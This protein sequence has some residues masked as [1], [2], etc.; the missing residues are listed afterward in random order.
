MSIVYDANIFITEDTPENED[1]LSC[2][3][4]SGGFCKTFSTF[5]KVANACGGR[6][7]DWEPCRCTYNFPTEEG[8]DK[9]CQTIED[10]NIIGIYRV[11][12]ETEVYESEF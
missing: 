10:D 2:G 11:T 4:F 6:W 7:V 8:M 1:N 3:P 12:Y 9:F 5:E